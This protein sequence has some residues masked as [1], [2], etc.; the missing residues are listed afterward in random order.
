MSRSKLLNHEI[1]FPLLTFR[2][3]K[4]KALQRPNA[5]YFERQFKSHFKVFSVRDKVGL[6]GMEKCAFSIRIK[7]LYPHF[8]VK[9]HI[10]ITIC[11]VMVFKLCLVIHCVD[12]SVIK[13]RLILLFK[14]NIN[15][16]AR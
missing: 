11:F 12:I 9:V 8:T 16:A 3:L 4:K 15:L 6:L 2:G 10:V 7:M 14:R 5:L 1:Y 13:R